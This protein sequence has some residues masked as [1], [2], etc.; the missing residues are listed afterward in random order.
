MSPLSFAERSGEASPPIA[1][2]Q[3]SGAAL[4]RALRARTVPGEPLRPALG[5]V[6]ASRSV[7]DDSNLAG[8]N[9]PHQPPARSG[10]RERY[11]CLGE[12]DV[13][14]IASVAKQP[15]ARCPPW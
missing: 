10:L 14:V 5:V 8:R 3:F 13:P 6:S 9:V 1:G 4:P 11:R 7:V 12:R 2:G 15:P